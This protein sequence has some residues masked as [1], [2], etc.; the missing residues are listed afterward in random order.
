MSARAD[1]AD[2]LGPDTPGAQG[3]S[4]CGGANWAAT[5][6]SEHEIRVCRNC[7]L[8]TLPKLIADAIWRPSLQPNEIEQAWTAARGEF[9]RAIALQALR[10]KR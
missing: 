7:A 1:L 2:W 5:W 8:D 3:C 6:I 10:G 9:W 4:V